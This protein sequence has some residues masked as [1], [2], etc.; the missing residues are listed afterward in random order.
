MSQGSLRG[1]HAG[2]GSRARNVRP[3]LLPQSGKGL[4]SQNLL[5]SGQRSFQDTLLAFGVGNSACYVPP[6]TP[7]NNY[8]YNIFAGQNH[9]VVP[10]TTLN[11]Q[12]PPRMSQ[13]INQNPPN[14]QAQQQ[15]PPYLFQNPEISH[16]DPVATFLNP[17]VPLQNPQAGLLN[18]Q[19]TYPNQ[20]QNPQNPQTTPIM[21]NAEGVSQSHRD[22]LS[23]AQVQSADF[24]AG[25]GVSSLAS[26]SSGKKKF[27][28]PR[29]V[30]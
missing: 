21:E 16:H 10:P 6:H 18:P 30:L 8:P 27:I 7:S 9:Q 2:S 5:A 3:S 1:G 22:M 25:S 29:D 12:A 23:P 13:S 19:V 4:Q 14:S 26:N 17:E 20:F 24:V 28:R 15:N 11:P